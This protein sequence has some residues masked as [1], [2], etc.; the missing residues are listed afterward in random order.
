MLKISSLLC[1]PVAAAI[2]LLAITGCASEGT[3][4]PDIIPLSPFASSGASMSTT[5]HIAILSEEVACVT[6]S[7]E[8]RIHCVDRV[9]GDIT[10]FGSEG[11]G[12]GEFEA[13]SAI[14]RGGDG[15]VVAMDF[16]VGGGRLNFF[17]MDGILV[18]ETRLPSGF[19]V[20]LLRGGHLFGFE[21]V[22]PDL[23]SLS[24]GFKPSY[25][26]MEVDASSG[27]VLWE[28]TDLA[29]VVERECFNP[30][31]GALT[32]DGGLVFEVCEYELAFFDHRDAPTATVIASP[33]Y[34]EALPNERD[35][36]T[37]VNSRV[38]LR[39][40]A[41]PVSESE[42]DAI[43]AEFRKK[44]KEWFLGPG[45]FR[46]DGQNRLWVSTTRDRDVFS[47]FDIWADTTYVGA[48]RVQDR[49]MG[50]DIFGS[51]LVTLVER[52]PGEDGIGER[53]MDWYDLSE[54]D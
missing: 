16:G 52:A 33:S 40:L 27:E 44:P 18:S 26:P 45:T 19:Q 46:F 6:D 31:V 8:S 23:V 38:R 5:N 54:I 22:M 51:T 37:H 4:V 50:F 11:K 10:I 15:H 29:E 32:P 48:V 14:E 17:G 42:I 9:G 28:R 12:P 13:L 39:S 2:C 7:Y 47:Y 3:D 30:A 25:V 49:L 53:E 41:G 34:V 20:T 1:F 24:E 21:L 35:I 43:A 36:A